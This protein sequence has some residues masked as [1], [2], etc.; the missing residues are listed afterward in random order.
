MNTTT[1]IRDLTETEILSA[2]RRV[3]EGER[4]TSMNLETLIDQSETLDDLFNAIRK[5]LDQRDHG[6]A[7][8][9]GE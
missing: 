4:V 8:T 9:A 2:V 3:F 5:A 6:V 1:L 7:R